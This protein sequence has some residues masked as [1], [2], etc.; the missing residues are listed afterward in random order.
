MVMVWV[1]VWD[2]AINVSLSLPTHEQGLSTDARVITARGVCRRRRGIFDAT[3]RK[4]SRTRSKLVQRR[5]SSW[6]DP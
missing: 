6:W 3:E 5:R 2:F 1:F 4:D